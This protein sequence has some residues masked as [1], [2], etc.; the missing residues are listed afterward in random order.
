M[1]DW[2]LLVILLEILIEMSFLSKCLAQNTHITILNMYMYI[3]FP[4]KN[5][6]YR[7]SNHILIKNYKKNVHNIAQN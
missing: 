7:K 1:A 3:Y 2:L 5:H 6:V 4:F